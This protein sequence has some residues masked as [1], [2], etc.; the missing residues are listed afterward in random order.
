MPD[1]FLSPPPD[2]GPQPI[3]LPAAVD[4]RR[5]A[6]CLGSAERVAARPTLAAAVAEALTE[7]RPLLRPVAVCAVV[8]PGEVALLGAG[9]GP[10]EPGWAAVE[11]AV[12]F[13]ATI[14]PTVERAATA[15]AGEGKLLRAMA[16]DAVASAACL[17][18]TDSLVHHLATGPAAAAGFEPVIVA[19][20]GDEGYPLEHQPRLVSLL[21]SP[22]LTAAGLSVRE[23]GALSP[24]KA[25]AGLIGLGRVG[26]GADAGDPSSL[27]RRSC[28][29]CPV[30]GRCS[31]AS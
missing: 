6:A 25:V 18:L 15:A 19:F 20:P 2:L 17:T 9:A 21:P 5:V 8:A 26:A 31:F 3:A 16:L 28:G 4:A 24:V 10:S 29:R 7:A 14:G 23:S 12:P 11:W 30:R 27:G 22:A 1:Q 13:A